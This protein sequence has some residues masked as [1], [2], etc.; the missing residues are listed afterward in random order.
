V[1]LKPIIQ[2]LLKP[3]IHPN[4]EWFNAWLDLKFSRRRVWR[5]QF[6][7]MLRHVV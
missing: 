2:T 5:W 3:K 4:R 6:S 1:V 7:G